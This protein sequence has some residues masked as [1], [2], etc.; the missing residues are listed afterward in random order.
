VVQ[1]GKF[2]TGA[3]VTSGIDFALSLAAEIFSAEV[4]KRIQLAIEYD[5]MPP[6]DAGSPSRPDADADQVAQTIEVARELRGPLI[7]R[8]AARLS[9][10]TRP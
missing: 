2:V 8:A 7:D 3:G 4:A 6:F 10:A 1:D 9:P 5:P